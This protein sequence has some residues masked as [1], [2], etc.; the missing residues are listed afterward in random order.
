MD[1]AAWVALQKFNG[2]PRIVAT[3]FCLLKV[4][5]AAAINW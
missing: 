1:T 3:P 5:V 2:R 4:I